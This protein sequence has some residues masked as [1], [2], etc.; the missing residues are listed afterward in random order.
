MHI[1]NRT[2]DELKIGESAELRRLVTADDLLAYA[3]VSG[4]HNPL[5]I[6]DADG[7]GDGRPEARAPGSFVT[8]LAHRPVDC[9][10]SAWG[11]F[12]SASDS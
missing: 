9:T 8:A 6:Y 2:F 7:D 3:N 12:P 10:V 5:H 1:E 11:A 4:N